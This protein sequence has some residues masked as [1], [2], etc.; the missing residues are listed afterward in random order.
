[1][2][3]LKKKTQPKNHHHHT[4]KKQPQKN[5]KTKQGEKPSIGVTG[6]SFDSST[7]VPE[8][9]TESHLL[10]THILYLY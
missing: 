7:Q 9:E 3:Y 5:K 6:V 8:G 2:C 4:K 1:M 10:V